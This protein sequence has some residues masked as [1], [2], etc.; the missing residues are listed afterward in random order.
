[1]SGSASVA[2]WLEAHGYPADAALVK[3]V[4]QHA[5]AADHILSDAEIRALLPA[6][7]GGRPA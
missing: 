6:V 5:R 3:R 4:L 1:M 2:A 7:P